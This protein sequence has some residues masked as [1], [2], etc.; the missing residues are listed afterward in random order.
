MNRK[1]ESI[2]RRD[3]NRCGIHLGGC[4]KL[5]QENDVKNVGHIYPRRL[6][7]ES[8]AE[9]DSGLPS[10]GK[11][12]I[13]AHIKKNRRGD[14]LESTWIEDHTSHLN[15]Q[16]MCVSCNGKMK[17]HFPPLAGRMEPHCDCCSWWCVILEKKGNA[18]RL[19]E[20]RDWKAL[21]DPGFGHA[22][23]MA[24]VRLFERDG[25]CIALGYVPPFYI[26]SH[27]I[28]VQGERTA[29]GDAGGVLSW[30]SMLVT[31]QISLER[32]AEREWAVLRIAQHILQGWIENGSGTPGIMVVVEG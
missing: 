14:L 19:I 17:G 2:L 15:I 9:L 31:N 16:P 26:G 32:H 6:L 28:P 20:F 3:A 21:D 22:F 25:M 10:D 1:M 7:K 8:G 12:K 11:E 30:P 4:G 18:G 27:G 24:F 5:L 13:V 23:V 29:E